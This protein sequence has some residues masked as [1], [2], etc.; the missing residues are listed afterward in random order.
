MIY[1]QDDRTVFY[2]WYESAR[3]EEYHFIVPI[4]TTSKE[5]PYYGW[6]LFS[7]NLI[8]T[9]YC[10]IPDD[11]IRRPWSEVPLERKN[12][13]QMISELFKIGDNNDK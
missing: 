11:S 10:F 2:R 9:K 12:K 6:Q 1:V 5:F 7:G 8:L 4:R 3:D 13:K